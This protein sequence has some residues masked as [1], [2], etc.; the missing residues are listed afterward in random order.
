MD[1]GIELSEN[2]LPTPSLNNSDHP[3]LL[4]IVADLWTYSID[5]LAK[6]AV[7]QVSEVR[8]CHIWLE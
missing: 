8:T 3:N 2:S 7:E 4:R 6:V 1:C 5:C